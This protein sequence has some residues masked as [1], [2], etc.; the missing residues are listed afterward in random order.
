VGV[1]ATSAV[2]LA[3]IVITSGGGATKRPPPPAR[4]PPLKLA[5]ENSSIGIS[6]GLPA[7]WSAVRGQ[8]FVQLASHDRKAIVLVAAQSIARGSNP[9]LL[10]SALRSIRKTDGA[11]TVKHAVGTKLGGLPARSIVVYT[12]NQHHVPIRILVGVALAP[13]LAYVLEAFTARRASLRDLTEAQ[14]VVFD[15][16]LQ[17]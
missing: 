3:V 9:P 8:G 4:L 16:R 2:I 6:G 12:R 11:M 5:Y 14:E 17:G 10:R 7:G 13:R 1:I 15:L